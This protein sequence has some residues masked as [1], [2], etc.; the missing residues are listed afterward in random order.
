MVGEA[1]GRA[2]A[3]TWRTEQGEVV[4]T[5]FG[6]TMCL[7]PRKPWRI[8]FSGDGFEGV[9]RCG[10]CPGCLE[11]DRRRLAD[12]LQAKYGEG[13]GAMFI[14]RI[15]APLDSHAAIS[16]A[17]HR[18]RGLELEP[19]MWRLG[20]SSF[21]LLSRER[22]RVSGL[23]LLAG[24]KHRVEPLRLSRGR[25]AWRVLTAGL[26]VAREIYGEQRNRFYAR[27]LPAADRQKWEVKKLGSY[28]SYS[29][30]ASPR[31]WT[32]RRLVLVP[33]EVWQLRRADRRSLRGL[34]TRASDPEGV[35]RVMQL[36]AGVLAG[37]AGVYGN[38]V[39][40]SQELG[41]LAAAGGVSERTVGVDRIR[42]KGVTVSQHC[43]VPSHVSAAAEG[44]SGRIHSP[45]SY[46][47]I[48][49]LVEARS[50]APPPDPIF[51]P[52]SEVGGYV[53]SEH[54]QGELMPEQLA[55][56]RRKEDAD[57]RKARLMRESQEIIERMKRKSP[58]GW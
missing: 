29:R 16:H 30:A 11:F 55:A 13:K 17:L 28:K 43:R 44:R 48:A 1:S 6:G 56:A 18:R 22:N 52:T 32:G 37:G 39:L 46:Q 9:I 27:G 10:E 42:S 50:D 23:L 21:A 14:V 57:A 47:R 45:A 25:R 8:R 4:G 40:G 35:K 12:R 26:I 36:V 41:A 15:W 2:F 3:A 33:P 58:K 7:W 24:V 31:A 34:L 53:S 49:G 54:D 19:G 51:T 20:A 5:T 38:R